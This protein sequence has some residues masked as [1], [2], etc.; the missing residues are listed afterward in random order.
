ME[1]TN[2]P[3]AVSAEV[4]KR[5]AQKGRVISDAQREG[6]KKGL[7]T[8]RLKR[9][10]LAKEKES[11]KKDL[12]I[13]EP[14]PI[15][16]QPI[17]NKELVNPPA[18]DKPKKTRNREPTLKASE[19]NKFK[20]DMIQQMTALKQPPQQIQPQVQQIQPQERVIEKIVEKQVYLT[21]SDLLNKLF[22]FN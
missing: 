13:P 8:L 5:G 22:K 10:A 11:K 15:I 19:L 3:K 2:D 4:K 16:N 20:E 18:L 7:E 9:E 14:L 12:P 6:L 17:V 21:G 1:T